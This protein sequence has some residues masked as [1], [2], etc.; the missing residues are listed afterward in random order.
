MLKTLRQAQEGSDP[1]QQYKGRPAKQVISERRTLCLKACLRIEGSDRPRLAL[2][3]RKRDFLLARNAIP[4][5]V[6]WQA[7]GIGV[8]LFGHLGK[9]M[10]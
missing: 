3:A 6:A 8:E 2:F 4:A 7:L 9:G 5:P 10:R 1:F